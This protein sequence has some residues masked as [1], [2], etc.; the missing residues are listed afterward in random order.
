MFVLS[1]PEQVLLSPKARR[2]QSFRVS[3]LEKKKTVN[4]EALN[5]AFIEKNRR[6]VRDDSCWLYKV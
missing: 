3:S 5:G 2:D 1:T 6:H 4:L